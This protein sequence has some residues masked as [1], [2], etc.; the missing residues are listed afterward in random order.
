MYF[1]VCEYL[2]DMLAAARLFQERKSSSAVTM[3]P[4]VA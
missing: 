4:S 3:P 1:K 2:R